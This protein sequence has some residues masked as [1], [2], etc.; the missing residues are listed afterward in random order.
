MSEAKSIDTFEKFEPINLEL[1]GKESQ[2]FS[3]R[4][5]EKDLSNNPPDPSE[6]S[7][8]KD[9]PPKIKEL[10]RKKGWNWPPDDKLKARM[11]KADKKLCGSLHTPPEI[12]KEVHESFPGRYPEE[13]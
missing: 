11:R 1:L 13:G 10:L 7:V 4:L 12:L 6:V 9:F 5:I 2:N 8:P 3:K